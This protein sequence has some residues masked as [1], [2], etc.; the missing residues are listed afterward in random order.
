MRRSILAIVLLS[1]CIKY[2]PPEPPSPRGA[3]PVSASMGRTW[4]AV[5]DRFAA[6]NIPIRTIERVSGLIVTDQLSIGSDSRTWADCGKYDKIHLWPNFATYNLLVRGDSTSSTVKATVRWIY[7][8]GKGASLECSTSH[9][10]EK[11]FESDVKSRAESG[12][13]RAAPTTEF[14]PTAAESA[15]PAINP[16]KVAAPGENAPGRMPTGTRWVASV[17]QRLYYPT[18][19]PAISDLSESDRLYFVNEEAPKAAGFKRSIVC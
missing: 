8:S 6:E 10:W 18:T 1:G 15:P 19:C 11:G 13:A 5:I 17:S 2:K 4:D 16:P 3:T 9:V 7:L 14:P 12:T